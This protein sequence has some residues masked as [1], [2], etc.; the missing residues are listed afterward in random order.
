MKLPLS[1]KQDVTERINANGVVKIYFM[2][3]KGT[4]Y[5]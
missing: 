3:I 1:Q 5:Y 2:L 4:N